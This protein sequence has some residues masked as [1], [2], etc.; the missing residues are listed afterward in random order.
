MII[1]K[2]FINNLVKINK[3]CM[4]L[5]KKINYF[6]K[7]YTKLTFLLLKVQKNEKKQCF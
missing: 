5:M 2:F 4:F 1:S 7:K 3:K 6:N